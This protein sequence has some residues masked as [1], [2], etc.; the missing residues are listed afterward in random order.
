MSEGKAQNLTPHQSKY[1][2]SL[3]TRKMSSSDR[4]KLIS[5][6]LGANVDPLPYQIDAALFAFRSPF[7]KGAILA[8]E[9]GL[10]KTIE[11]GIV[12]SQK[13]AEQKRSLLIVAPANLRQQW[14]VELQKRFHIPSII[15]DSQKVKKAEKNNENLLNRQC[16]IIISYHFA[17]NQHELMQ[18]SKWDLVVFDEAH[19]LRNVYKPDNVMANTIKDTFK[20]TPKLL[21]TATPLQNTLLELYGL[22]SIIDEDYFGRF[23]SFKDEYTKLSPGKKGEKTLAELRQRLKPIIYRSLRRQVQEYVKYTQRRANTQQF[24]PTSEET[25]LYNLVVEYLARDEIYAFSSSQRALITLLLL[26]LLG[27][28]SFAISHTLESIAYRVETEA[29]AGVRRDNSGKKMFDEDLLVTI[30]EESDDELFEDNNHEDKLSQS[31]IYAMKM[32]AK[33]LHVMAKLA[34]DITHE[35]KG[36]ALLIALKNGFE[37][38]PEY[39]AQRKALIFT[40]STRTQAYLINLL[41]NSGYAGKVVAFNGSGGG[42]ASNEI[43]Q[44]WLAKHNGTD[45]ISG[46]KTSDRR[47]A[48]TDYFRDE[49]EIMVAT[50]AAGEGMNLQFCS[51]VINYDLPWNPQRVEQRIGRCHRMGQKSDVLVFNFLNQDNRAEQRILQLLT[52]K[53][54]LFDGVFGASDEILGVIESG[55]DFERNIANLILAGVRMPEKID[56]E[57]DKLQKE[58]KVKIDQETKSA[59][60]HLIDN[61]DSDVQEKLKIARGENKYYMDLHTEWMWKVSKYILNDYA[62]FDDESFTLSKMPPFAKNAQLGTYSYSKEVDAQ[63]EYRVSHPL[64]LDVLAAAKNLETPVGNIDFSYTGVNQKI[65]VLE[66]Y[67]GKKGILTIK[68]Y[69]RTSD[70]QEEEYYLVLATTAIGIPISPDVAAKLFNLPAQYSQ[71]PVSDYDFTKQ[72]KQA[73]EKIELE[74]QQRDSYLMNEEFARIAAR[75]DDLRR[76]FRIRLKK[77]EGEIRQLKKD[78]QLETDMT[79]RLDIQ[80]KQIMM[81]RKQDEEEHEY[82]QKSR[83]I[84]DEMLLLNDTIRASIEARPQINT[85][86]TLTWSLK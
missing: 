39:K 45:I 73:I 79:K 57:F 58:F 18:S 2:A 62:T 70:V 41:E 47:T 80:R 75:A 21:L 46:V 55:F 24:K 10:G 49:A 31:E 59:R 25:K 84:D 6:V 23:E 61:F 86:C 51:M 9:V 14:S 53:F 50:E 12:I 27:S 19:K 68:R 28:S 76:G 66:P 67:I 44:K 32:E 5:T 15:L 42:E 16:V 43:Y 13:W 8:D 1:F 22:V 34:K 63:H 85:I 77:R 52:E 37:Q 83:T 69:V 11:A 60:Q 74:A 72:E 40:E 56:D 38:L 26:K 64:A 78:F 81:H 4:E 48:L 3:L 20:N 7:S 35:S 30:G 33:E 65:S 17:A 54:K 71:S 36:D 29:A 82:R